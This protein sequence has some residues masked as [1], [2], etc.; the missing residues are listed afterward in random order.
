MESLKG[1]LSEHPFFADL[2]PQHLETITGCAK[3][4]RF[5]AGEYIFKEG[6]HADEF[7]LIRSGKVSAE[8]YV[9]HAEPI[10]IDIVEEGNVF[11]FSWLFPP[12][13]WHF[14]ARALELT[15]AIAINGGCLR[16]KEEKDHELGHILMKH[17]AQIMQQLL[18]ATRLQLI[19][20]YRNPVKPEKF[21]MS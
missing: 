14:D 5:D 12:Y 4:V 7:Y 3:N 21:T 10:I 1:L 6:E 13:R 20:M 17:F 2:S 18:A 19:D 9:P 16:D 8:I 11:G 15:R